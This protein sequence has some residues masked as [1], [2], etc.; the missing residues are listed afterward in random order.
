MNFIVRT[1]VESFIRPI[2][3][4]LHEIFVIDSDCTKE[5]I[6]KYQSDVHKYIA[7]IVLKHPKMFP[8]KKFLSGI[9]IVKHFNNSFD[10]KIVIPNINQ[11]EDKLKSDNYSLEQLIKDHFVEN[12]ERQSKS[13]Q[14]SKGISSR[15]PRPIR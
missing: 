12:N 4:D 15:N 7:R 3:N 5:E 10:E 11:L 2:K 8:K 14:K 6:E 9:N 13:K 1:A